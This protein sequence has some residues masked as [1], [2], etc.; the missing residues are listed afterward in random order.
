MQNAKKP[1]LQWRRLAERDL[2]P[3]IQHYGSIATWPEERLLDDSAGCC[4]SHLTQHAADGTNSLQ[5]SG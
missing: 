5:V 1:D 2:P 3:Y 4:C